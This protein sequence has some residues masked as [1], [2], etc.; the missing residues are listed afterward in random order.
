MPIS[1][2]RFLAGG[3]AL[4]SG[5]GASQ[6]L[7]GCSDPVPARSAFEDGWRPGRVAHLLPTADHS[8]IFL[9]ASFREP[10]GAPV[11]RV[12]GIPFPGQATEASGRFYRFAATGL[13]PATEYSLRLH[14]GSGESLC[15]A[16][17]LRTFPAP[18]AEPE[19][20]RLLAYTCAGG[21]DHLYNTDFFHAFLPIAL[22][23]RLFA[24]AL[25]FRPDAAVAIGDH[26]Y[27]DLRGRRG[28]FFGDSP[29]AWWV[30][31]RFDR[32]AAIAGHANEEV[33][34]R[35]LG[36]QIA[37]LYDVGFRSIPTFFLQDDHDY[38]ENDEATDDLRTFPPDGFM[39]AVA[40]TTQQLYYPELPGGVGL[41]ARHLGP[42][43]TSA[44]FGGFRFGRLC[45]GLLYDCRRFLENAR[46]PDLGHGQSTFLPQDV[47]AWLAT[48]SLGS[49]AAHVVHLPS[50]PVLWSAGK[51]LEWYPDI[52]DENGQLSRET[53][54]PY[55][56]PGWLAQHDR[57]LAAASARADRTPLVVSGDLHATGIGRIHKSGETSFADNPVV[58]LLSGPISTG[59]LGW[60]SQAR[61]QLPTPSGVLDAEAWQSP[62]EEN[63][64]S[65]L[66]FTPGAV[67]VSL[68]RWS[69][70][71]GA[72]AI[73]RLQPYEV[74]E[75]A[76][77]QA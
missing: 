8:R 52:S 65:L 20:F 59:Q 40:Q 13:E 24:R 21:P 37:G 54:K 3:V 53:P 41:P 1:R 66:D 64:F 71:Q 36:P 26:V 7:A 18:D 19:S 45:E 23:Q 35:A 16:W 42:G 61:G 56:A 70:E 67:K 2:R 9:K 69:P 17:P 73:D 12:G 29:R 72:A 25:S 31:G 22:R 74:R 33:L 34:H 28:W 57:I 4:G 55:W 63:G 58:S 51:W 68:F 60:P 27:W 49:D 39:R 14:A 44:H 32:E 48:R 15:D 77:P 6:L 43:A 46:D 11:L 76:R 47:E 75:I 30:A 5:L 10:V 62:R 50:T 38:S